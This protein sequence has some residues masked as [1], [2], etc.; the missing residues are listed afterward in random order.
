MER[1]RDKIK[2]SDATPP[3]LSLAG[4]SPR[5]FFVRRLQSQRTSATMLITAQ[6]TAMTKARRRAVARSAQV[7]GSKAVRF[8]IGL[9]GERPILAQAL[10]LEISA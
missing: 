6:S 9:A 2:L 10:S 8:F 1:P 7:V 3:T 5:G 4:E